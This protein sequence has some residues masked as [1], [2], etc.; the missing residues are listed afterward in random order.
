MPSVSANSIQIEYE[1]FGNSNLPPLLLIAG[2]A[3]QLIIWD[4][5]LCVQLAQR[6]HYV[7]RFDN[8]DVGLSSKLEEAG[9][10]D[11]GA[12]MR[13]EAIDPPYTIEDMADDAVGLLD[14]LGIDKAHICGMSMGG[15][16]A[17]AVVINHP[18]RVLSLISIYSNT[19]NP[20]L[21]P[22]SEEAMG[23]LLK[24]PPEEREANIEHNIKLWRTITGPGFDFDEAW[25]R[26][27]ATQAYD[28]AFY[29]PGAA[30]Q[31]AAI[32]TQKNRKPALASVSVP[33]L[34]IHGTDDP[35]VSAEC[36]KD[37]AEAVPDAEL[38][39]IEGMGHDLPHGD[40][41]QQ[42]VDAIVDHTHK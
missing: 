42:I 39:I 10:P 22:P 11:I 5:E 38:K 1:T 36:G 35:M 32:F 9:V 4:D 13:G 6:G 17:Q 37:T 3:D 2:L 14:A 26:K 40:A 23:I 33:T 30:R 19:G 7:I 41:W 20:D 31:M 29:L 24:R 25:H 8:R 27:L 28:R 21:P 12:L 18:R 15:M 34:V 16:I